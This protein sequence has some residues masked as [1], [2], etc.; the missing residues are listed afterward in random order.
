[1]VQLARHGR[2]GPG[3]V[4]LP[5][6]SLRRDPG[7]HHGQSGAGRCQLAERCQEQRACGRRSEGAADC[8]QRSCI[9][10]RRSVSFV[11][12]SEHDKLT[13]RQA[14]LVSAWAFYRVSGSAFNACRCAMRASLTDAARCHARACVCDLSDMQS[15]SGHRW[16]PQSCALGPLLCVLVRCREARS[17]C[18]HRRDRR[19]HRSRGNDRGSRARLSRSHS[20]RRLLVAIVLTPQSA[21]GGHNARSGHNDRTVSML[22]GDLADSAACVLPRSASS[23]VRSG[24]GGPS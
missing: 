24:A 14:L 15:E 20:V 17:S 16:S 19:R 5:L 3:H 2:R 4:H 13:S 21:V 7:F 6:S 23:S 11:P 18:S 10:P 8:M 12:R 9:S 1:M 22:N